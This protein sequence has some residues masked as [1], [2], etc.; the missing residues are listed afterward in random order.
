M[1]FL[2]LL[3]LKF[4]QHKI[5][6]HT[7]KN[8]VNMKTHIHTTTEHTIIYFARLCSACEIVQIFATTFF[9]FIRRSTNQH[10]NFFLMIFL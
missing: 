3:F 7:H 5:K 8:T 10:T 2:N 4:E 1:L 6:T 9:A